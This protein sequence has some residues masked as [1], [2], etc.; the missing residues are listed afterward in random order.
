MELLLELRPVVTA[1]IYIDF[2]GMSV[3]E[4]IMLIH[5]LMVIIFT[6]EGWMQEVP[7]QKQHTPNSLALQSEKN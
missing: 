6:L 2:N 7:H 3:T 4:I 5:Q 1:C